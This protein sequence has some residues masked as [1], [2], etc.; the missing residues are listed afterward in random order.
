V[1]ATAVTALMFILAFAAK[2]LIVHMSWLLAL[3]PGV[4]LMASLFV[5]LRLNVRSAIYT[6]LGAMLVACLLQSFVSGG[7][8]AGTVKRQQ[9]IDSLR[10]YGVEVYRGPTADD[11]DGAGAG[12]EPGDP[13]MSPNEPVPEP[14]RSALSGYDV[15]PPA[16]SEAP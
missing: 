15:P 13:P 14:T 7:G 16:E 6:T 11:S 2:S 3:A 10:G 4:F 1:P 5:G 9:S 12:N 8:V